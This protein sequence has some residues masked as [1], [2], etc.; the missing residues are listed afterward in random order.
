M[1]APTGLV[2]RVLRNRH[3]LFYLAPSRIGRR[4]SPALQW[5]AGL[6]INTA[7]VLLALRGGMQPMV[8][9]A[10]AR[11]FGLREGAMRVIGGRSSLGL[12]HRMW[13]TGLLL[14]VGIAFLFGGILP[15]PGS[16][17]PAGDRWRYREHLFVRVRS[18][19]P[20]WCQ[21]WL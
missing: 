11:L 13:E 6:L 21:R 12:R 16:V 18:P 9:F 4:S 5:L 2:C 7:G 1:A 19:L 14:S 3:R 8:L 15:V 17:Y 20:G 10:L